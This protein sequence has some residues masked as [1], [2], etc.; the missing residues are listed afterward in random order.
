MSGN[1]T[2]SKEL[3]RIE[4]AIAHRDEAELRWALAE[5][6]LRKKFRKEHSHLWHRIE[7]RVRA[8]LTEIRGERHENSQDA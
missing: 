3:R 6:E 1:T 4:N 2:R 8:A 7:K 5:C